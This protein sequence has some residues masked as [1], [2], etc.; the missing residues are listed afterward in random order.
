M[1]KQSIVEFRTPIVRE[2]THA[3]YRQ[4]RR[5]VVASVL[6]D[7]RADRVSDR[8]SPVIGATA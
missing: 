4:Q 1:I 5:R 3:E 7:S 8:R 6:L 2:M